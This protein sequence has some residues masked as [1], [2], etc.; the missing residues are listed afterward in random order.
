[1]K[2]V[3]IEIQGEVIH[4]SGAVLDHDAERMTALQSMGFDVF[5]VTHDMLNDKMQLDTIVKSVCS[6][7]GIR[8]K[9]K[10]EAMKRA[11]ET[12]RFRRKTGATRSHQ[13]KMTHFPPSLGDQEL[14]RVWCHFK[15]MPDYG[16]GPG[17]AV[18]TLNFTECASRLP[19]VLI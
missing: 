9:A 11:V 1:M 15:T 4:G 7:L 8:Y 18:H 17:P 12:R 19:A 13:A 10:S 5:L 16:A 3:I 14:L 2:A 6:R